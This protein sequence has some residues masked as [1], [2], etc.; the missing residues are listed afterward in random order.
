MQ[1]QP[2]MT[3]TQK[4]VGLQSNVYSKHTRKKGFKAFKTRQRLGKRSQEK[5]REVKKIQEA[6]AYVAPAGL[7]AKAHEQGASEA[8]LS[9]E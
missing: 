5:P 1:Q 9:K 4:Q 7:L 8:Y 3:K 6:A 2:L